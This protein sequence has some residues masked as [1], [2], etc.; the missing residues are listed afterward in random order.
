MKFRFPF[1]ANKQQRSL[2]CP[3]NHGFQ[4]NRKEDT[5]P[6]F[7]GGS[8]K[9]NIDNFVLISKSSFCALFIYFPFSLKKKFLFQWNHLFVFFFFAPLPPT[10]QPSA[11]VHSKP[12]QNWSWILPNGKERRNWRNLHVNV[13]C[14]TRF[15]FTNHYNSVLFDTAHPV[16][17]FGANVLS[18]EDL[19]PHFMPETKRGE[20]TLPLKIHLAQM[21]YWWII[22][23]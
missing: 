2:F 10:S 23:F 21:F 12:E 13:S 22:W 14:R 6:I 9:I 11:N 5:C 4:W 7:H 8:V 20:R 18:P 19:G 3:P 1:P 15:H 17:A 16:S